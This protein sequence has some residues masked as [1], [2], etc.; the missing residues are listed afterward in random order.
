MDFADLLSPFDYPRQSA[1]NFTRGMSNLFSGNATTNDLIGM[2]PAVAGGLVGGMTMSPLLGALAAGAAQGVGRM[3]GHQAFNA[4]TT[5]DVVE[6]FGGDRNSFLQ[7]FGAQIATDPLTFAT[8]SVVP[9]SSAFRRFYNSP[10]RLEKMNALREL[11]P[12]QMAAEA[13]GYVGMLNDIG[14]EFRYASDP[15][16]KES[17]VLARANLLDDIDAINSAHWM[18]TA[19]T[20]TYLQPVDP[21]TN[22]LIRGMSEY[23]K[24]VL[25]SA[26]KARELD[27][28]FSAQAGMRDV[29]DARKYGVKP[30]YDAKLATQIND[31]GNPMF[32]S[33]FSSIEE[34][35]FGHHGRI[36]ITALSGD[37]SYPVSSFANNPQYPVLYD[38]LRMQENALH[39][40]YMKDFINE[41]KA[42][43]F[44]ITADQKTID[45]FIRSYERYRANWINE[46]GPNPLERMTPS[47][48][49]EFLTSMG[50]DNSIF[51]FGKGFPNAQV[52]NDWNRLV[53]QVQSLNDKFPLDMTLPFEFAARHPWR[54]TV[55]RELGDIPE[56][57]GA[58][59]RGEQVGKMPGLEAIMN[60]GR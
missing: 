50:S 60:L 15:A 44:P 8:A 2:A 41:A 34:A 22:D 43:G 10:G 36:P 53:T 38:A 40:N 19:P 20:P 16:V 9:G 48:L 31:I 7:N 6:A 4:P 12:E 37:F 11:H 49:L 46:M 57:L 39:P 27:N 51:G 18:K 25:F 5:G 1:A 52:G 13:R 24:N 54:D 42:T 55:L 56:Y 30:L 45:K 3:T 58:A 14:E 47:E 32:P 29:D 28:I 17:M 26:S 59:L 21:H 23:E 33:H 35:R